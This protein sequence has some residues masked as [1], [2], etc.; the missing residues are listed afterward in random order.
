MV[1]AL[2]MDSANMRLDHTQSKL[3]LWGS[4]SMK[5]WYFEAWPPW[6]TDHVRS[7][8]VDKSDLENLKPKHSYKK[9]YF[10]KPRLDQIKTYLLVKTELLNKIFK[11]FQSYSLKFIILA[12]F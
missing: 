1:S 9:W 5:S 3:I 12:T 6:K 2:T 10:V 11:N 8:L 4:N 7:D